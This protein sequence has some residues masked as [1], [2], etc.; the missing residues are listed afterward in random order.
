M[1]SSSSISSFEP[2]PEERVTRGRIPWAAAALIATVVVV[3]TVSNRHQAW[4]ADLAGWQW[5]TK[6]RL[7]DRGD[8]DGDIAIIGSSVLFHGLNPTD[9]NTALAGR[10]RVVNLAL[11]GQTLQHS[12]QILN[13][14]LA[15]NARVRLIV[16]ELWNLKV[17]R[18]SWLRGPYYRSWATADEFL[19]S[20][21]QCQEPSVLVPFTAYRL[22]PSL[23]YR[24]GLDNWISACLHS[25][26]FDDDYF[27]RNQEVA[28]EMK[29][30][31]GFARST[32]ENEELTPQQVPPP[33]S[34]SWMLDPSAEVWLNQF[35]GTCSHGRLRV[36][37]FIPPPPPFVA[38]DRVRSGYA[39]GFD[40][41]VADLR[42]AYPTL[43][44]DTLTFS[45]YDLT[46]FT[47]DHHYS[48]K[49]RIRLSR[50]FANWV[51]GY[52]DTARLAAR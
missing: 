37:L 36:V 30:T 7:F 33:R 6:R 13:R 41:Y 47:D 44:L 39:A 43:S 25:C 28:R 21:L 2:T 4:F 23:R 16:L 49:G 11:N 51:V 29:Q 46:D 48:Q 31:M 34:R 50:D 18:D 52:G 14:H 40:R 27:R 8:L 38:R 35:F 22:F 10:A 5:E 24:E 42:K 19:Q 15:R 45:N 9:A 1:S 32:F 17:E 12:A 26:R 20:G 3:E